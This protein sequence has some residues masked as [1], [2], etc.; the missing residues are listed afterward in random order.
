MRLIKLAVI[1]IIIFGGILLII[2]SL[3]PSRVY[4]SRTITISKPAGTIKPYVFNFA[5]WTQW[6][7]TDTG[8]AIT[9]N[10][11][12]VEIGNNTVQ[13]VGITD[14]SF[15]TSWINAS[16]NNQVAVFYLLK[17]PGQNNTMVEWVFEQKVKWYPWEK[18]ASIF[19]DKMMGE[20]M[21]RS[22]ENLKRVAET[23]P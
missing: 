22:L 10:D 8:V 14:T 21:K 3:I 6:L 20:T 5:G 15:T 19:N 17:E 23:T 4:V 16:G 9:G 13:F 12:Q 11:T 18:F 1:S 2:S 7:A